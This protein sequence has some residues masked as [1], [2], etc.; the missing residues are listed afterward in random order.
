MSLA[1]ADEMLFAAVHESESGTK[2]TCGAG[3]T[4]SAVEG[5]TDISSNR[6]E[7]VDDAEGRHLIRALRLSA[8]RAGFRPA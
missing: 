4:M 2:R 5:V 7:V 8:Q 3:L 1:C 6:A